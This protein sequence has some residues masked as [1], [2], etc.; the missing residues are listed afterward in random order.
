MPV[1][2]GPFA[3]VDPAATLTGNV[4]AYGYC[5]IGPDAVLDGHI[6]VHDTADI[7][8]ATISRE[9]RP[10]LVFAGD[11]FIRSDND[12]FIDDQ[13]DVPWTW[14]VYRTARTHASGKHIWQ[15]SAGCVRAVDL[16][17]ATLNWHDETIFKNE[18]GLY[19]AER[20]QQLARVRAEIARRGGFLGAS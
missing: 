12:W 10:G 5:T 1:R 13:P 6:M 11:C 7:D 8:G 9:L 18:A 14:A 20:T 19:V 2:I 16:N 15:S 4:R 3:T 17:P